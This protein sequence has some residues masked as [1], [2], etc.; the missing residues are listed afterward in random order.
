MDYQIDL[1]DLFLCDL[2]EITN[3]LEWRANQEIAG[4]VGQQILDRI[5]DVGRNPLVGL[6]M[7]GRRETRRVFCHSY[8]I[9]YD[10]DEGKRRVEILRA[11]HGARDP[12][13]L[14]L[15]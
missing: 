3:Y 7:L 15:N 12:K 6:P 5:V 9:Y 8:V 4:Q 1:S 11:W 13:T 2:K 10:V 14:R